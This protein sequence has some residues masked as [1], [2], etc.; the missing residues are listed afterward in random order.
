MHAKGKIQPFGA[1]LAAVPAIALAARFPRRI[2]AGCPGQG[3]GAYRSL[4]R[5]LAEPT[6]QPQLYP[7]RG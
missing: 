1:I 3:R 6:G 5:T 7:I 4:A 2:T